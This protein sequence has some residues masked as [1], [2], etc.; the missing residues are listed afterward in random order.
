M[1]QSKSFE[2][3]VKQNAP[4]RQSPRERAGFGVLS[5]HIDGPAPQDFFPAI[6][7]IAMSQFLA[8]LLPSPDYSPA[9]DN[10]LEPLRNQL[11]RSISPEQAKP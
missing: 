7:N 1:N 9:L 3:W 6:E 2:Q 5:R 11:W 4:I 8:E 10:A